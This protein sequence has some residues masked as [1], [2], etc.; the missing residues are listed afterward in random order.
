M[1][2]QAMTPWIIATSMKANILSLITGIA[3]DRLNVFQRWAGYLCLFLS[4]VHMIPF[5]IQP[6]WRMAE[7]RCSTSCSLREVASFTAVA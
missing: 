1:I 7:W 2:A 4:L 6:V 3:A 5:F